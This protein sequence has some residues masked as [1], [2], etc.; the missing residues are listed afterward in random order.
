MPGT[1][2][3]L[4]YSTLVDDGPAIEVHSCVSVSYRT[5]MFDTYTAVT[6]G[7]VVE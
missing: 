3:T 5:T 4:R 1:N 6:N 7:V 2:A